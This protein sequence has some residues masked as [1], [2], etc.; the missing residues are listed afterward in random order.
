MATIFIRKYCLNRFLKVES[1]NDARA[2][3]K[4]TIFIESKRSF[5]CKYTIF[6]LKIS[7]LLTVSMRSFDWFC[8]IFW[9]LVYDL[10]T[11]DCKYTIFWLRCFVIVKFC[12][13]KISVKI[14]FFANDRVFYVND[15]FPHSTFSS[16]SLTAGP[17]SWAQ[18]RSL[19]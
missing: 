10:I 7:D 17:G 15:R 19:A 12:G 14:L 16:V 5:E 4:N 2:H 13:L 1:E 6:W 9:F 11:V 3:V 18:L 8:T